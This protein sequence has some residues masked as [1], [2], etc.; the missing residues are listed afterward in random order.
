MKYKEFWR[1][2]LTIHCSEVSEVV[3]SVCLTG[4][5]AIQDK[6]LGPHGTATMEPNK[7]G[8]LLALGHP[9]PQYLPCMLTRD[10]YARSHFRNVYHP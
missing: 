6:N 3:E 9:Q 2:A 10:L 8:Q 7:E 1:D 5:H 4:T